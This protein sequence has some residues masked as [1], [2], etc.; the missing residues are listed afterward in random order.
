M[1]GPTP[2]HF[3]FVGEA[4]SRHTLSVVPANAGT[5]NPREEF[6]EDPSF[7]TPTD[8]IDRFRGMGP[9]VRG[10]DTGEH[11]RTASGD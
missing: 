1:P 5:H 11:G 4:R 3:V 8:H 7:G 9:R 10:D 6:G 2:G